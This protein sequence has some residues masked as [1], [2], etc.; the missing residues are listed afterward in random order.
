MATKM[1]L[2]TSAVWRFFFLAK[3]CLGWKAVDF[4]GNDKC[5][6]ISAVHWHIE[7]IAFLK[8]AAYKKGLMDL[9]SRGLAAIAVE[10]EQRRIQLRR[11]GCHTR[12]NKW[13]SLC[14]INIRHSEEVLL[15]TFIRV[16]MN[17]KTNF[18]WSQ[19]IVII[20]FTVNKYCK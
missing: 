8:D 6:N 13:G 15:F 3:S 14:A 20:P 16:R 12:N 10:W 7:V 4:H 18:I 5:C 19:W 1:I 17:L 2:A 9:S 11:F